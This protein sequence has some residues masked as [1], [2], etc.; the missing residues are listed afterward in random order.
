MKII[1]TGLLIVLGSFN[2]FAQSKITKE[3]EYAVYMGIIEN[4]YENL[5][6]N[7]SEINI[8]ILNRTLIPEFASMEKFLDKK[9]FLDY[10]YGQNSSSD[11]N[12]T[13]FEDLRESLKKS[14]PT[15][16]IL[17]EKFL[18]EY[19]YSVINENDLKM[20]LDE[21]RKESAKN[22]C[23]VGITCI[24]QPFFKKYKHS[25]GYYSFSRVGFDSARKFALAVAEKEQ[26]DYMSSNFYVLRKEN[27]K[28]KVYKYFGSARSLG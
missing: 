21:G 26:G 9:Y 12:P 20:L 14:N 7:K 8:V 25:G 10:M 3:E 24:W 6:L 1:L 11:F 22:S 16:E 27:D 2:L 5:K 19:K 18:T 4:D 13:V 17:E 28:W 15:N 23:Y